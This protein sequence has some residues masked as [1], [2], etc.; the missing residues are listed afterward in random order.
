MNHSNQSFSKPITLRIT[1]ILSA[2]FL[3]LAAAFCGCQKEPYLSVSPESL[4]FSYK[5]ETKTVTVSSNNPWTASVIGY[6]F[7]VSP[8]RG[9]G[10][11]IVN[12]TA[13]TNTTSEPLTGSISFSSEGLS[14][15]VSLSQEAKEKEDHISVDRTSIDFSGE[16]EEVVVN[17][18]YDN[19]T[20]KVSLQYVDNGGSTD[21]WLVV[22]P[23]SNGATELRIRASYNL[24][25]ERTARIT[26]SDS[27]EMTPP[28]T[29]DI[30]QGDSRFRTGLMMLYEG[31][32]GDEWKDN[33][34][35]GTDRPF[36]SWSG[37]YCWDFSDSEHFESAEII[38]QG[39]ELRGE[40]P[41]CFDYFDNTLKAF[42][43][44]EDAQEYTGSGFVIKRLLTG[45][46]PD[47]FFRQENL[48][49]IEI[50]FTSLES[51]PDKFSGMKKLSK[52]VLTHNEL[53]SGPAP[54]TLGDCPAIKDI[55]I[56]YNAF[57]GE[58]PVEWCKQGINLSFGFNCFTGVIPKEFF[59]T[60]NIN[61]NFWSSHLQ[62][63]EVYL[64]VCG[65]PIIPGNYPEKE[66]VDLDGNP[67]IFENIIKNNKYTVELYWSTTCPFSDILMPYLKAF[68]SKYHEEGFE[69]IAINPFEASSFEI[70]D[71][72]TRK[73]V[74]TKGYS[75]YNVRTS[76]NQLDSYPSF[77]P[78]AK[79]YDKNGNTLFTYDRVLDSG[80]YRFGNEASSDLIPFLE[81][82]FGPL[83]DEAGYESKD[84]SKDGEV[85]TIQKASAG[86]GINIVL[87]GDGYSDRDMAAGGRYETVMKAAADEFFA[88]EPYKSFQDRFNVYSVKA[89][90][91]NE[92]I[93]NGY[94][95]ALS[96]YLGAG[97]FIGGDIDKCYEY[98]LNVPGISSRENT[99]V[100]VIANSRTGSGT[101]FMEYDQSAVAF[102]TSIGNKP[103][104]FG[105]ALRHEA[106]GHGFAFLGDEYTNS[107]SMISER[108]V[109]S[110]IEERDKYGWWANV[111]FTSD[112]SKV[113]WAK[114]LADSRYS[115]EVS[116]Y[117]GGLT[118][119]K[120]VWRPSENS[121]MNENREYFNAPSREAIYKR[122]M[123][124][125]G[126][127]F[128]QD[129]FFE[130]DAVNRSAIESSSHL[131]AA[132]R[133]ERVQ[134]AP[135]VVLK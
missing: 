126:E 117:E 132:S 76:N 58:V 33:G 99:L 125:S 98:A 77:A 39:N 7:I 53:M 85:F 89:V 135:P 90:S 105:P 16:G 87:L 96:S 63:N 111:D 11:A 47:S 34:G 100:I 119:A 54:K 31:L 24:N 130:Y 129:K 25:T 48:E 8:D 70:S 55:F 116:V 115:R 80:Q 81:D 79:V 35:W 10:D 107:S 28:V 19:V 114:F 118:Y 72:I 56:R 36:N 23:L 75:W 17:L 32:H 61:T 22:D 131:K 65:Y 122:I 88:I 110:Y 69:I 78:A 92:K 124:L 38:M 2:A 50:G 106:G 104:L 127:S 60:E 12:V 62:Q 67:I 112:P 103:E 41:D 18:T 26:I 59:Q 134:G 3:I 13:Q 68:Y 20:P 29:I 42:K 4:T 108:T 6:G 45:T 71:Q 14:S 121:M 94:D 86:K 30:T 82:L 123:I 102:V 27:S 73:E 40:I 95:T 44:T 93:G 1:G 21:N 5:G 120:G 49:S 64:D 101:T 97:M 91:R 43:L 113:K 133:A 37:V 15:S 128:S 51:M 74:E 46:L 52:F 9:E 57:T 109:Q 66:L 84:F 83:E